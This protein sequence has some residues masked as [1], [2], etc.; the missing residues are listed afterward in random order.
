MIV[1]ITKG[2]EHTGPDIIVD[3]A[4]YRE[5][6]VRQADPSMIDAKP[7]CCI[8]NSRALAQYDDLLCVKGFYTFDGKVGLF[9][10]WNYCPETDTY[11]DCT[12]NTKHMRYYIEDTAQ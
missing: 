7:K 10:Y 5:V 9:H 6:P 12:P 1:S 2:Y 3:F 4:G 8:D 11:W